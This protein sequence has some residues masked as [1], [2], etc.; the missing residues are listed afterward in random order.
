M[1]I[2]GASASSAGVIDNG[3]T[4]EDLI[5]NTHGRNNQVNTLGHDVIRVRVEPSDTKIHVDNGT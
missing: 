1:M 2:G 4:W 5:M 3:M